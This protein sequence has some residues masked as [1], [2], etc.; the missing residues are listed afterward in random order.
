MLGLTKMGGRMAEADQIVGGVCI[1]HY[2]RSPGKDV[3]WGMHTPPPI[4]IAKR[5]HS[6]NEG[7]VVPALRHFGD[8]EMAK[9]A[10]G[11]LMLQ[12]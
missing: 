7:P 8:H 12:P 9:I 10:K 5:F 6:C 11:G 1:P 2:A 3:R 4:P